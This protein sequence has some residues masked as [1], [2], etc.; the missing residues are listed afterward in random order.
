[1]ANRCAPE[2]RRCFCERPSTS[3]RPHS[4]RTGD[5]LR[6]RL[7][8]RESSRSMS[9]SIRTKAARFRFRMAAVT[10]LFGRRKPELFFTNGDRDNQLMSAKYAIQGVAFRP[11]KARRWSD[12]VLLF[13][14]RQP[15]LRS[16]AGRQHAIA[17]LSSPGQER[18]AADRHVVL[19][20]HFFDELQRRVPGAA[21]R[22]DSSQ[23]TRAQ[24]RR[25]GFLVQ[26]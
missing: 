26:R 3:A 21:T 18:E 13:T 25:Y 15:E 9:A 23:D 4:R 12:N 1:M 14:P 11:E 22:A 19:L 2:S 20:Q 7:T 8:K 17:I 16:R 6:I 5:G 10:S 24:A